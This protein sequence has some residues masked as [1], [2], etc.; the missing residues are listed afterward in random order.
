LIRDEGGYSLIELLVV[1][2]IL[3]TV[4]G[5][6]VTLFAAGINADADQNRRFQAQQDAKV[7]LDRMR[8]ESHAACTISAPDTYN[9]WMS[10]V[11]F[12]FP[13]DTCGTGTHA[14]TWCTKGSGTN[15]TLYR[16]AAASCPV[17]PTTPI[18]RHLTGGNIFAYLPPGSHLVTSADVGLGTGATHIVTQDSSN[19]SPRLHVDMTVNLKPSN[20]TSR[21][22][23]V[24]DITFRNG[25]RACSG[26]AS[27]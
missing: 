3:G 25:P 27:C 8:R 1:I 10:S 5:A 12:Y 6:V 24:D 19:T 22:H 26:T 17:S 23:L 11:T 14:I 9:T 13:S 16:V 7:S 18:A 2:A 20:A 4:L 15:Y 21:F